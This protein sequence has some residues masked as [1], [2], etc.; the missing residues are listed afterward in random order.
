[1]FIGEGV[2]RTPRARV[3][4]DGMPVPG[5]IGVEVA[6]SN[7]FVADR[8]VVTAALAADPAGL[9]SLVGQDEILLEISIALDG[10]E[11]AVPLV[12]GEADGITVD[13]ISGILRIEGR[14]LSAR[15]IEART[16]EAFA[17][18][19]ASEIATLLA[20]RHGLVADVQPTSTPVGR[21]WQL[22]HDRLMLD[23]FSRATTEWDLLVM[24][25]QVE[26][27][28]LWVDGTAL[29]F[30]SAQEEG[31][32]YSIR[33]QD[34][35]GI[36]LERALSLARDVSV[37]VKSWNSRHQDAFIQTAR[38]RGRNNR[39]RSSRN[40]TL[41]VPNLSQDEA[42]KLAQ[43]RLTELS[44]HE[45]TVVMEMPGDL[46]IMP[47]ARIALDGTGTDFDQVYMV[48]HVDRYLSMAHGFSQTVRM[49]NVDASNSMMAKTA[50]DSWTDS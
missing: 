32:A 30:R 16:H 41:V 2:A 48:D 13:P 18:R 21:Y 5:I 25:A 17:N 47:R 42:L 9:R 49:T 26:G 7:Y 8:F 22:Q 33:V 31:R 38:K 34:V 10:S 11:G 39:K 1:M 29:H 4:A 20:G 43:T 27:F 14:D 6:S 40:Y 24:L 36:R 45:R 37:T 44:R 15:L 28:D 19:T 35:T 23:Q 46:E 50:E 3:L 12:T